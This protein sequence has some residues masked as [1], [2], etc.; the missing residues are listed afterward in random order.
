MDKGAWWAVVHRV[1]K[2]RTWL[3]WLS[4]HISMTEKKVNSIYLWEVKLYFLPS[5]CF[6]LWVIYMISIYF[7]MEAVVYLKKNPTNQKQVFHF[8]SSW[9]ELSANFILPRVNSG[10]SFWA[11]LKSYW[12]CDLNHVIWP[13]YTSVAF[14]WSRDVKYRSHLFMT[15]LRM[16]WVNLQKTWG[17]ELGTVQTLYKCFPLY[18]TL[19]SQILYDLAPW[20]PSKCASLSTFFL[21]CLLLFI[22]NCIFPLFPFVLFISHCFSI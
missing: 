4:A 6:I 7:S 22:H 13:Y 20:Y 11:W 2:S 10:W 1:A 19:L 8:C 17:L 14:L 21:N 9:R 16:T 18:F 5:F 3:K 12:L 15:V